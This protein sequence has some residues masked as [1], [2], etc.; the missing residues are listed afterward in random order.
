MAIAFDAATRSVLTSFAHVCTGSNG[1]LIAV[2][3]QTGSAN[4]IAVTYNG[5]ALS[6]RA[7]VTVPVAGDSFGIF[8]L[9]NPAT[10][11]NTVAL[12]GTGIL[13]TTVVSYTGVASV[14]NAS[15]GTNSGATIVQA[16]TV[17]TINSWVLSAA[18][19]R[20]GPH[21]LTVGT[22][23][24][25]DRT[26]ANTL[27]GVGDSGPESVGTKNHTWNNAL[28]SDNASAGLEILESGGGAVTVIPVPQLLTLGAG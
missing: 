5:V 12:T 2:V 27:V 25:N 20:T 18:S 28:T 4:D 19:G 9:A 6:K 8:S 1:M 26:S 7:Y 22:G 23:I 13:D 24:T 17:G 16:T 3:F 10:G 15:T 11:S 14:A 21:A